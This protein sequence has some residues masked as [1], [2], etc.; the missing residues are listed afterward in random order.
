MAK[1]ITKYELDYNKLY[2]TMIRMA[3]WAKDK[4]FNS[5]MGDKE[6]VTVNKDLTEFGF[7]QK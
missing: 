7:E 2:I 3:V 6:K 1:E 4:D 5:F